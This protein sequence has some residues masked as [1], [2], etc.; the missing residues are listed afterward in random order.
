MY[1]V[2]I[3]FP[4]NDKF[5]LNEEDA[6]YTLFME[7]QASIDYVLLQVTYCAIQSHLQFIIS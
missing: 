5:V 4:V 6:S 2:T 7:I 3:Q 1:L